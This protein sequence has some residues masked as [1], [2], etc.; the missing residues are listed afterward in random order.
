MQEE[1]EVQRIRDVLTAVPAL[2]VMSSSWFVM[3]GEHVWP[4]S[5][6][7]DRERAL[8]KVAQYLYAV[9]WRR[10]DSVRRAVELL[11]ADR[12][13]RVEKETR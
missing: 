11:A 4:W 7:T 10:G 9:G 12:V 3:L 6:G 8:D 13:R 1:L 2:P 5:F